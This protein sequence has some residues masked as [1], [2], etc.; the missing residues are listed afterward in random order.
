MCNIDAFVKA[1]TPVSGFR[2]DRVTGVQ[3]FCNS[4]NKLVS[5]LS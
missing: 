3:V 5:F 2:R 4:M 1:V